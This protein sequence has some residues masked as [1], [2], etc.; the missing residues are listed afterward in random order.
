[1]RK[2]LFD[3]MQEKIDD[4]KH[5]DLVNLEN[6]LLSSVHI[7][8]VNLSNYVITIPEDEL[9]KFPIVSGAGYNI[10]PIDSLPSVRSDTS[11][12]IDK[13]NVILDHLPR[14]PSIPLVTGLKNKKTLSKPVKVDDLK[15]YSSK[16]LSIIKSIKE[17]INESGNI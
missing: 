4:E 1:M 3:L 8:P 11:E 2:T 14:D 5:N 7:E 16:L 13:L 6:D 17:T 9:N 12:L 15:A 10:E